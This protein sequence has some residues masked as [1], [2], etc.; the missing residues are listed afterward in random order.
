MSV[1]IIQQFNP[2][3]KCWNTLHKIDSSNYNSDTFV[4]V[5]KYGG[6]YRILDLGEPEKVLDFSKEAV[7]DSVEL[8]E[9]EGAKPKKKTKKYDDEWK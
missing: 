8:E 4:P 7:V 9:D 1:I 2:I 5:D 3:S 6:P